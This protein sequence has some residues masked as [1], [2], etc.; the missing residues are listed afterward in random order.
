MGA[1]GAGSAWAKIPY[2]VN[3]YGQY[4]YCPY[5]N[6]ETEE[7]FAGITAGGKEGGY[8]QLGK[9]LVKLNKS[10]T[11]QG[12]FA[13]GPAKEE[14]YYKVVGA[15]NGGETLESPELNVP[16][17]LGVISKE[18]QTQAEWPQALKESFKAAKE[19]KETKAFVKVELAGGNAL[20]EDDH[21]ISVQ[22]IIFQE[23]Y[24]FKLPLKVKITS[25]WL[26]KLGGGP[27]LV[28]NDENPVYQLLTTESPGYPGSLN[29]NEEFSAVELHESTL[30]HLGWPI[31]AASGASGCG[32][33]YESYVNRALNIALRI[34]GRGITVLNGTLFDSTVGPVKEK[35]EKG[36]L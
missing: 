21:A 1:I 4:K 15:V 14:G 12:G 6:P 19:A 16:G 3:T 11:L 35:G 10:I 2:N 27:C 17:G 23:G 8:F 31:E 13:D 5:E 32:G 26:T 9:V 7:C 30:V 34:P 33:E 29:F 20:F 28:G 18:I 25:A 24:A 22:N 36:E